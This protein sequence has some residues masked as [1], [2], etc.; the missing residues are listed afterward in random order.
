MFLKI[1]ETT[2]NYKRY[3]NQD[4]NTI[5][6]LHGWGQN[7]E[8]MQPVADP[9]QS[10]FDLII[11]DLPGFG[12]SEEPNRIWSV[13]DYA[14]FVHQLLIKLNV[15]KPMVVGHSFGG[16]VA[17]VYA[18][19]YA[20]DK[21]ILFAPTFRTEIKK[22]STKTKLLKA[23]KTIP[24]LKNF[25]ELAK[26]HMGSTDYRNAS[27]RMRDILVLHVNTDISET[28]KRI[29][30]PTL[31]IWG[32]VDN[33]VSIEAAKQLES[34]IKDAGLVIY[35]NATHYAYLERIGQTINVMRSFLGR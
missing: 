34:L 33:Q 31:L 9:F 28:L 25:E 18:T 11:L 15:S 22:V 24:V 16:K 26:K 3:G 1:G 8:M 32:D 19:K 29:E 27:P 17:L 13:V 35:E 6:Y 20:C 2:V 23:M 4:G 5:V 21:L 30:C 7:I 10:D 12:L 14:D